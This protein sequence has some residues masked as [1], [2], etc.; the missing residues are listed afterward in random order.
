ML[1]AVSCANADEAVT[2]SRSVA[3]ILEILMTLSSPIATRDERTIS[4]VRAS[5]FDRAFEKFWARRTSNL[6]LHSRATANATIAS[7]KR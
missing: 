6:R 1:L 2:T 4:L 5:S 3:I 7:L